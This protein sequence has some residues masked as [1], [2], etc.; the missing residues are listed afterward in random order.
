MICISVVSH[1]QSELAAGFLQSLA[2]LRPDLV[3]QVIYTSN[4][5]EPSQPPTDL[6]PIKLTRVRNAVPRGYGHNHNAAFARC[7]QPF[8]CVVNPDILMPSDPFPAL[9]RCLSD[10]TI[11]LVAPLVT[12]PT[13]T[14]ENTAR[15]LYTPRELIRQ[16][17]R[18]ENRGASADWLAGM[19]MMFRSDVFRSIAGFDERYFLYIEDV[20]ICSRLRLAGWHLRQ[21]ADA[22]V[23]HDAR[24]QSHQ[25]MAFTRWHIAGML[26]YWSSPSFWRYRAL[27]TR[28]RAKGTE[29]KDA[30]GI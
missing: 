15:S 27:L 8:Y 20:D 22:S 26:R 1:G 9:L 10:P 11:G 16:K 13:L 5:P 21:C 7:D 19:F 17:L 2:C 28:Q 25:S 12:T 6:G 23:I 4:I 24:K 30:A 14:V 18:P 3:R 29:S